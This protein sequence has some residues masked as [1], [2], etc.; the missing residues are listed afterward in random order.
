[1][2]LG[3][4]LLDSYHNYFTG[5]L[6]KLNDMVYRLFQCLSQDI[7]N[8]NSNYYFIKLKF[9]INY[10]PYE[11]KDI[12]IV[13]PP[14]P[15]MYFCI[16]TCCFGPSATWIALTAYRDGFFLQ[17]SMSHLFVHANSWAKCLCINTYC[18]NWSKVMWLMLV[19]LR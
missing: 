19:Y 11:H 2:V 10:L 1:M 7:S 4:T 16:S 9:R 15:S 14:K 13:F 6:W 3:G 18:R 5:L 12:V 17:N 8:Y